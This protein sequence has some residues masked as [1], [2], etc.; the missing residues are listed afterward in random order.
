MGRDKT[1]TLN[2]KIIKIVAEENLMLIRGAVPGHRGALL[3][4]RK[5][6]RSR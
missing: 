6:N 3:K 2:L 4:I 1:T 5:S